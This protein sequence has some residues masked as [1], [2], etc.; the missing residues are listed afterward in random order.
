VAQYCP[1]YQA[2]Q[3]RLDTTARRAAVAAHRAQ[4]DRHAA[5]VLPVILSIQSA[6]ADAAGGRPRT[7]RPRRRPSRSDHRTQRCY[8]KTVFANSE[9][10]RSPASSARC[11]RPVPQWR[12]LNLG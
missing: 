7:E 6:G 1:R 3:S 9:P 8:A 2:R 10:S 11:S 5:R 4:A 12:Y